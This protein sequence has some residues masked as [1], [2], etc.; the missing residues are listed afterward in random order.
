MKRT[1]RK[2]TAKF[3]A[4]VALEALKERQ[5]LADLATRFELHPKQISAWKREFQDNASL[6]FE[7]SEPKDTK[8]EVDVDGLF[9]QIGQ[10]K[11]EN[12]FLK[13]NLTKVGL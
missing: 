1:R 4:T 12:D 13:K 8:S 2:F 5:S 10:L 3:K 7:G 6:A 9:S 11:V